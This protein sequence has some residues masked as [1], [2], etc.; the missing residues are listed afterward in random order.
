MIFD[1][2]ELK[3]NTLTNIKGIIH[4]GGHHGQE[5]EAYKKLNVPVLFF[6][7]L[8]SNFNILQSKISGDDNTLAFQCALG[9]ENKLVTMNVEVANQGQS[10]SIL[11][12]KKHLEQ[13]PS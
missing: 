12:P 11:K 2:E 4:V 9:N 1:F 7:P 5:Y 6:E 10:S 8:T 13:Y 3:Q